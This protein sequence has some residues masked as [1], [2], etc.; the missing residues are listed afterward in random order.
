NCVG[1]LYPPYFEDELRYQVLYLQDTPGE[2]ILCVLYDVFD[3]I[4]EATRGGRVL[5]HCSQG[6]SRS[7]SLAIAYLMWRQAAVYDDVFLAVKAARGVTNPNIGFI[8]QLL[9][10]HKRRHAPLDS[11]RLYRIAPQSAAAAQHLVPKPVGAPA[12]GA[13]LDPRGA[14]V[15]HAPAALTIWAGE[16]C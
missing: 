1:F 12:G 15:L 10:W 4:E 7:A 6:V 13:S 3:F 2:D 14:F 16:A 11:C 9:Q 8:C 5:I